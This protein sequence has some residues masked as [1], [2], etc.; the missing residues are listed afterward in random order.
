MSKPINVLALTKYSSNGASSRLRTM[1]YLPYLQTKG[2]EIEVHSLYSEDYLTGLYSAGKRKGV[3][4]CYF[5]RLKALFSLHRYDLIWIEKEVFPYCPALVERMLKLFRIPYVVD[6]DDA[7]YAHYQHSKHWW[8]RLLLKNKISKV[9]QMSSHVSAGN[10]HLADYAKTSGAK[11][12]SVIPTVPDLERY[13][14]DQPS[15]RQNLVV[16]W[17]GSPTTQ[18]YLYD[19]AEQLTWATEKY[20]IT[21]RLMGAT[22]AVKQHL[23]NTNLEVLPWSETEEVPFIQSLDVGIMPLKDGPWEK[24]KCGYKLIQYMACGVSV[25]G[26]PVGVNTNIVTESQS[27]LLADSAESWREAL[28][29]LLESPERRLTYSKNGRSAVEQYY[30]L[31]VQQKELESIWRKVTEAKHKRNLS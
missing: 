29:S 4:A 25:I 23:P 7:I 12:V 24:G 19:I 3:L 28:D 10:Q 13:E 17:I 2:F 27:G 21:L 22:E 20:D 31:Q 5:S 30:S 8:A 15:A 11:A 1:Q 16:G 18:V 14:L 9:M 6:Y 26:S